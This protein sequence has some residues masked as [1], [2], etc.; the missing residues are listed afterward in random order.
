MIRLSKNF[1]KWQWL[2]IFEAQIKKMLG[3]LT[4]LYISCVRPSTF[5][6]QDEY[7]ERELESMG[8]DLHNNSH[9]KGPSKYLPN[10]FNHQ[11]HWSDLLA[12]LMV[13]HFHRSNL[14][15]LFM[16]GK[17]IFTTKKVQL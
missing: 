6:G 2:T 11:I 10:N 4:D 8:N 9:Y 15:V 3:V 1:D 14:L 17:I 16:V 13:R 7:A 5:N 12:L